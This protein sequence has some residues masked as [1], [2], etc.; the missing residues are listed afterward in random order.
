MTIDPRDVFNNWTSLDI[1]LFHTD[2][3]PGS[4]EPVDVTAAIKRANQSLSLSVDSYDEVVIPLFESDKPAPSSEFILYSPEH[5]KIGF[6]DTGVGVNGL[7][8]FTDPSRLAETEIGHRLRFYTEEGTRPKLDF[9]ED[10]LPGETVQP[11]GPLY[12]EEGTE[13]IDEMEDFIIRERQTVVDNT[14]EQ[15][16]EIGLSDARQRGR[17]TGPFTKFGRDTIDGISIHR[18]QYTGDGPSYKPDG[19]IDLRSDAELFEDNFCIADVPDEQLTDE[20][21]DLFPIVVELIEVGDSDLAIVPRESVAGELITTKTALPDGVDIYI[22]ELLNPVPFNRRL[23]AVK[24]VR[25]NDEKR[26]LMTGQRDVTFRVNEYAPPSSEIDLNDDQY[27]AVVWADA[28]EDIVC[29]HGP[30]GTGKTRTLTAYVWHVVQRGGRVLI[31]AH[32]NQAVDNL[33]VGDSTINQP[34]PGTLHGLVQNKD[35]TDATIARVGQ[36]SSNQVVHQA[37]TGVSPDRA[38]IVAATTNG[39]AQFDTNKFA[40]A[41]VDEATQVSRPSTAIAL[42]CARKLV[43]AGDHKQLPPFAANETSQEE[44]MHISLFESLLNR[45]GQNISVSLTRQYRMHE[46]I[47]AFPNKT[48]YDGKL[49]TADQ[50]QTWTIDDLAPLVGVDVREGERFDGGRKSYTNSAEA[51]L[52][53]RQVKLLLAHGVAPADIGVIAGYSAQKHMINRHINQIKFETKTL[54]AVAEGP[55]NDRMSGVTATSHPEDL[56]DAFDI[57]PSK[58]AVDT[59]DAFQGSERSVII[60]SF[61]RSNSDGYSGFLTFPD[62]GR[63][64]L[65]V[66]LTRA[67]KRLVLIGDWATLSTRAPNRTQKQSCAEDYDALAQHL[68]AIGQMHTAESSITGHPT[69]AFA[70]SNAS[71]DG[72]GSDSSS[73]TLLHP[74]EHLVNSPSITKNND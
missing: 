49:T 21:A 26:Q 11:H 73:Y 51:E 3:E 41:V 25:K 16:T 44:D 28:A 48:Y 58:I 63:R 18:Y 71:P 32:S 39:A 7:R 45:Y 12:G 60:V 47:V 74:D 54:R 68:Q 61:V 27:K 62:E 34:E 2:L 14:W 8:R 50:N 66:A 24:K 36:N 46:Q 53:T 31:T 72:I 19:K 37:Y 30:P 59:V 1:K 42:N 56:Q 6:Y 64:R 43:L 57:D 65:N 67:R 4:Y 38:D 23:D 9:P 10:S 52:V 29:I 5:N 17:V 35:T 20:T 69:V 13:F 55:L 15:Y 22:H 33:L 40:V 70:D